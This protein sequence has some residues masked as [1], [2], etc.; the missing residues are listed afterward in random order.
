MMAECSPA[1]LVVLHP[2]NTKRN[3]A[4][5]DRV[6]F[7][8]RLF[9][10]VSS[11]ILLDDHKASF[12]VE[13]EA[14]MLADDSCYDPLMA[15]SVSIRVRNT[16]GDDFVVSP[17]D[18]VESVN[19]IASRQSS[20]R[21]S[22]ATSSFRRSR[23]SSAFFNENG[24]PLEHPSGS[25]VRPPRKIKSVDQIFLNFFRP[26]KARK[27]KSVRDAEPGLRSMLYGLSQKQE[28]EEAEA[29]KLAKKLIRQH[30][31]NHIH[32]RRA[33]RVASLSSCANTNRENFYDCTSVCSTRS[34]NGFIETSMRWPRRERRA[35]SSESLIMMLTPPLPRIYTTR[36]AA[37]AATPLQ[38]AKSEDAPTTSSLTV[39]TP[40]ILRCALVRQCASV[41]PLATPIGKHRSRL[42]NWRQLLP[43]K[44]RSVT[45]SPSKLRSETMHS[46]HN[47]H[48]ISVVATVTEP[49]LLKKSISEFVIGCE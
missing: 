33:T 5:A 19:E 23:A 38:K 36:T 24:E 9:K 3:I 37:A 45:V 12:Y 48:G 34:R 42:D 4:S 47:L 7:M 11:P 44:L 10:S 20:R 31:H 28:K 2:T 40:I 27:S 14:E 1:L 22:T 15:A 26:S 39:D 32:P 8:I 43:T 13:S 18:V 35:S 6:T 29:K 21:A 46:L 25:I 30:V 17:T 41:E 16:D 49:G